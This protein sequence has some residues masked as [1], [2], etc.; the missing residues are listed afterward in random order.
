MSFTQFAK[1]KDAIS[2]KK[3][4]EEKVQE[5]VDA[6]LAESKILVAGKMLGGTQV[7]ESTEE[8]TVE[9]SADDRSGRTKLVHETTGKPIK[10]GDK[11]RDFRG[12]SHTVQALHPPKHDA[13]SG[14]VTTNKGHF[15]ASVVGGKF[16]KEETEEVAPETTLDEKVINPGSVEHMA[17]AVHACAT[18]VC[19]AV[20]RRGTFTQY[21]HPNYA[22]HQDHGSTNPDNHEN[23]YHVLGAGGHHMFSVSHSAKG[24][25]VKHVKAV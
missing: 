14:H 22:I 16:V 6:S 7:E 21:D 8:G 1:E 18:G 13:S 4:F 12:M 11:L 25:D 23:V 5:K 19:P 2:F 17:H 24:V 9:E 3:L 10:V 15:Y 20:Q